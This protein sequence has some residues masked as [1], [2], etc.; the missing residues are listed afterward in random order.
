MLLLIQPKLTRD[1]AS[2]VNGTRIDID[3]PTILIDVLQMLFTLMRL[4]CIF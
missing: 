2:A 4:L 3:V 1:L